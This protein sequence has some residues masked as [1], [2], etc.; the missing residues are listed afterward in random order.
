MTWQVFNTV[1]CPLNA[2]LICV[3]I[4]K[5]FKNVKILWH[6]RIPA[7]GSVRIYVCMCVCVS[8]CV[9]LWLCMCLLYV[10]VFLHVYLRVCVC[11]ACVCVCMC[12]RVCVCCTFVCLCVCTGRAWL[13]RSHSSA[14]FCF[15]LSRNSNLTRA[16]N[17]NFGQNFELE[18][19]LN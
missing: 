16:C 2:D 1:H 18:I 7:C 4:K 11:R 6:C 17:S 5:I 8:V 15:E 19:S 10:C 14:R 9:S 13:I 12:V 3:E